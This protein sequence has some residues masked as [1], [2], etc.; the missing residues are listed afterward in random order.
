MTSLSSRPASR[1][2]SCSKSYSDWRL[3]QNGGVRRDGS[4]P[5]DDFVN[6]PL[7]VH[8]DTVL[9]LAVGP[10]GFQSVARWDPQLALFRGG[11]QEQQ[12]SSRR[13]RLEL[14]VKAI[15]PWTVFVP[16]NALWGA[17]FP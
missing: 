10:E 9:A 17:R 15:G 1:S 6:A 8:P 11:V 12:L 7:V 14:P 16:F 5:F 2:I 13:A 4:F 3:S